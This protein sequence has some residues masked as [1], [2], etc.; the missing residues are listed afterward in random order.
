M[1]T[2]WPQR[3]HFHLHFRFDAF[4]LGNKPQGIP[5]L[6]YSAAGSSH[7]ARKR[8]TLCRRGGRRRKLLQFV[9]HR[10]AID[11]D[12]LDEFVRVLAGFQFEQTPRRGHN[13]VQR[14][15]NFVLQLIDGKEARARGTCRC[16][17]Q[18]DGI[19]FDPLSFRLP[20]FIRA[21][22]FCC[23]NYLLLKLPLE[24]RRFILEFG[25]FA[26]FTLQL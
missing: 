5:V 9:L 15:A 1:R 16:V 17:P 25:P 20:D 11:Q 2:E 7:A 19:P 22:K 21:L 3:G 12:A 24:S 23:F 26:P 8:L 18:L 4:A 13:S 10:Q 6:S 14:F